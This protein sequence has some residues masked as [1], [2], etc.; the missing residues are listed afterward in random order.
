MS[1]ALK[2]YFVD[3]TSKL[4][5]EHR[6]GTGLFP[7]KRKN[8]K[9]LENTMYQ[10]IFSITLLLC[11]I[12]FTA[13]AAQTEKVFTNDP[14][15]ITAARYETSVSKEGKDI[16]VVTEEDIKRSGKKN[17]ADVL[18]TIA[19]VTITRAGADGGLSKVY[20]RGGKS[21]NVLVMVDGVRVT[22]PNGIEKLFDI[23]GIITS[24]IE[25]IEVVK[26]AMSS[27]YG[28]EASGGVINIITKKGLGR[29]IIITGEAGTDNTF[30]EGVSVSDSTEK[31][32][33]IFS[34]THSSTDGNSKAKKNPSI[35]SYDDDSYENVTVSGKVDTRLSDKASLGATMN[36]SDSAMNID[37]GSFQDDPNHIYSSKFFTSR[38][39]FRHSPLSWWT[40]KGGVSYMSYVR[41]DTDSADSIDTSESNTSV[42][43]GTNV[44]LDLINIFKILDVN[45]LT[46]GAELLNEKGKNNSAYTFTPAIF[47]EKTVVTKSL[48]INDSVSVY[49]MFYLNAGG[50]YDHHDTFG[51][52]LTW[53]TS[54][55][56][57]IP[58]TETKLKTSAGSGFRAPSLYELYDSYSG[59]KDLKPETT[60]VYDAGFFQ[61]FFSGL[62]S[63]DCTCF[64][65]QHKNMIEYNFGTG[66]YY[67]A[68]DE[69][70]NR[71]IELA[72]SI[73]FTDLLKINY[74]YTYIDY[75]DSRNSVVLKR[76]AHK[77]TGTVTLTPIAGLD[78]TGT[79]LYVAKRY[80]Y[81]TSTTNVKLDPY[82]KLDFNI[83]YSFNEMLTFTAR[84]ENL[85]NADYMESYG[86]NTKGRS[87]FGGVEVVL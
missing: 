66:R 14:I 30:T 75:T 13:A 80:D 40:Y 38:G 77:H 2:Y 36:Y 83:R 41:E 56:V 4:I 53:D 69:I 70:N 9:K 8:N 60:L 57:V 22:D 67:N 31:S 32:S 43:D 55:A 24:N 85:T 76:P 54:A 79:Y 15:V 26:G 11:A 78:I 51:S 5:C 6:I 29:K 7:L 28:S 61:E 82:H 64:V 3:T 59:N 52:H 18:E 25:R 19:G 58:V 17:L 27:M 72:S 65:Q 34:A 47:D 81:L 49:D 44:N 73:R 12:T 20:L 37:D 23:S 84:G 62:M 21:S 45:I 74:G 46:I 86:Y 48:F 50:R 63:I 39:E 68:G 1:N 16:S 71:G 87:F 35:P 33:F 10:K 42:Y